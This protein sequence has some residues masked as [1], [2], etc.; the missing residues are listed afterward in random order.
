MPAVVTADGA[1]LARTLAISTLFARTHS[2]Y[3]CRVTTFRFTSSSGTTR[4]SFVSTSSILPGERRVFS[5]TF[6]GSMSSTPSSLAQ[7]TR[8]SCVTTTFPGRSPFLS[9]IAPT[10]TPS[11][12]RIA[13]GPSHGSTSPPWYS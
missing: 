13:A 5:F 2:A 6:S 12:K 7:T 9:S 4:P 10:C 11:V 8:P 1:W 3:G